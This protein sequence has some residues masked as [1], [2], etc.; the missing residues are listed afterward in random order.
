MKQILHHLKPSLRYQIRILLFPVLFAMFSNFAIAQNTSVP[1][2]NFEA[3]LIALGYDSGPL[4]NV[5]P[6]ANINTVTSLD[7]KNK[8]ISDLTGIKDFTALQTLDCEGN[9]LTTLD[10]SGLLNLTSL[11]AQNNVNLA[12]V[13][14][15]TNVNL[16]Y[17]D[18]YITSLTSLNISAL[19]NLTALGISKSSLVS[20]DVSMAPGLADFFIQENPLLS[21]L[22]IRG[23]NLSSVFA[24]DNNPK[25]SCILVDYVQPGGSNWVKDPWATYC[26]LTTYSG[27]V[28]TPAAPTTGNAAVIEDNYSA[29]ADINACSLTVKN[30]ATVT[31]P[32]GFNVNLVGALTVESGSTFTLSNNS[33]L[34]QDN[35]NSTNSGAINVNRES[36]PLFRLD[37]TLWSSPVSGA[38][39]LAN[40]SPLTSLN[41]FYTYN[42]GTGAYN[43][44]ASPAATAFSVGTGYLIRMPNEGSANYNVGAETLAYPGV[45]TGTPNN[46]TINIT[47]LTPGTYVAVG[48]PYPSTIG[49]D[50]FLSNNTSI[51]P[52]LYFWRKTNAVANTT[53]AYATWTLLG[54]TGTA[55]SSNAPNNVAP[56]GTIAVGQGFIV[57]TNDSDLIFTNTMR[58]A[59]TTAKFFKTKKLADKSRVWL[60]L[61]NAT[62]VFSQALIGYMDGAT[63]G[64]DR[65]IDGKYINDSPIALTS[66][67]NNEEYTIQGRP[68]FDATDVVALNFKTTVSGDYTIAIDHVDGLFAT[69]QDIYL[70]DNQTGA[71]T[72]LKE[73]SYS[74]SAVAGVDNSRFSLKYQ[75]TLKV[76]AAMLND[77]TVQVYKNK[78]ILYVNAGAKVINSIKVY[79]VQGRLIL[80]QKNVKAT[81]ATL[82]TL[83][84]NNQ[85]LIVR[86]AGEDNSE[87]TKKVMN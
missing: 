60:N 11:V 13:N 79:D 4:D 87:V 59:S 52:T 19:V 3:A 62:G 47:G 35:V 29:A 44:I 73:G 61:T 28:W 51:D 57:K 22:D 16:T 20:L 84:V 42:S 43:F 65:G 15:N 58:T 10:V 75:K 66:L 77:N 55:G 2:D 36:N 86:V 40:F 33:N 38:Q 18:L 72:N 50:L 24:A 21:S 31:I 48:N 37:F 46:G 5:V 32:S 14:V 1:D 34:L 27:G 69:G 64:I 67:I 17:L 85:V 9:N 39:T 25:L 71:E 12:T 78:G 53:S 49:A 54:G 74:F 80:E 23:T 56:D 45:F 76:D 8:N 63:E 83:K 6:T 82:N 70:L 41:R 26:S 81:T 30:N 68:A 7:L